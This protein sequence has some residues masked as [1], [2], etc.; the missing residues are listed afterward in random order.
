MSSDVSK[1]AV[2]VEL[3]GIHLKQDLVCCFFTSREESG[4]LEVGVHYKVQC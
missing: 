1:R 2:N 4:G 3:D